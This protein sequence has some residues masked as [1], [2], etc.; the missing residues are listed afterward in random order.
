M[1]L[2]WIKNKFFHTF[3]GKLILSVGALL[4]VGTIVLWKLL[5]DA[6]A[7]MVSQ[8]II[9]YFIAFGFIFA[10]SLC[11]ALML[12]VKRPLAEL[13]KGINT[14][15]GGNLD[16]VIPV[17]S[18]DEMGELA[19]SFNAMTKE[20]S[21]AKSELMEWGTTL[22]KKV[23][24][25]TEAIRRAQDQLIHSEKLASLGRM[26][27]GVAHE[28]NSPLT[29]I[30]TFGHLMRDRFPEGSADR[31]DVDVIIEQANRCANIIRGLLGFS[32]ASSEEK[33]PA[34]LN[35]V[36]RAS[37][38][39][40]SNKADFFNVKV[41]LELDDTLPHTYMNAPQI[42]QVFLNMI[43]NAA[44]AMEGRGTL[45]IATR[46]ADINGKDHVEVEFRDTGS[47]ISPENIE[48]IFEPF[49]TT[50]PVGKGTGLGLAVSHGLVKDHGGC[51]RI[52]SK[53]GEGTSFYIDF[54]LEPGGG[55]CCE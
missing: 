10:F 32:R 35:D 53:I 45:T 40:V 3:S 5:L 41:D 34:S 8:N 12:V 38:R 44:D 4:L 6:G 54:P 23:E 15:A 9:T 52:R 36:V 31:E 2:T 14:V 29:G 27:A 17:K 26:A 21:T 20:L 16:Y 49:F 1:L 42:Q 19:A 50:K 47:G 25:K 33:A 30:V 55:S 18:K 39:I 46:L 48:K 11:L 7:G 13:L 22:E 37:L 51:I 43:V 28:L 24:E